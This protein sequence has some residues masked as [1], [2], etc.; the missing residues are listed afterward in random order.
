[1]PSCVGQSGRGFSSGDAFGSG[2]SDVVPVMQ[3]Q[4]VL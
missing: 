4:D 3:V 2:G 1:M